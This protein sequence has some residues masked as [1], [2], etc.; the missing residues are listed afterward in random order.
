M[1]RSDSM[2]AVLAAAARGKRVLD[3]SS[4]HDEGQPDRKRPAL[5]RSKS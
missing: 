1:E 2:E 5:A 4:G 3:S